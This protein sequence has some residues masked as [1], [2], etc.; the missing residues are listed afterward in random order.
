MNGKGRGLD[1]GFIARRKAVHQRYDAELAGLGWLLTPPPL[2]PRAESSYYF[3]WLQMAAEV[4]DRLARHLREH[5]VY[6]TFRYYPLHRVSGYGFSGSL[7]QAERAAET[8]LCIPIHHS[9]SDDDVSR[10]VE[11]IRQFGRTV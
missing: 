7:P 9:L 10:V 4:R 3:Y 8:T 2:S 1:A 5:G 6:T 11:T